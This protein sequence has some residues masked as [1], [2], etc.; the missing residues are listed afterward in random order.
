MSVA[1]KLNALGYDP[2]PA[3]LQVMEFHAAV[4]TGNLVFVSGQVSALG[5]TS[6]RG[7]VGDD[8]D[9]DTGRKAA[10]ICA[11]NCIRAVGAVADIESI[12]RVVKV[13]GMV[14]VADGFN[15]TPGVVNGATSLFNAVFGADNSHA[16]S[17]VGMV[18]PYGFAVEVEA[19]FEL[20]A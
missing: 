15:D 2:S 13:L 11:V 8:V 4:R 20:R 1:D 19:V 17:A 12:S 14:N 10:E 3:P 9:L 7:R 18:I 6:I 16:R 5:E